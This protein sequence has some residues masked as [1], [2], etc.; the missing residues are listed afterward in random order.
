MGHSSS[1][2]C[3][4]CTFSQTFL[5][6]VGFDQFEYPFIL[7][8]LHPFAAEE[9]M[10]IAEQTEHFQGLAHYQ[11]VLQ[12]TDCQLLFSEFDVVVVLQDDEQISLKHWCHECNGSAIGVDQDRIGDYPCPNCKKTSLEMAEDEIRIMW[13]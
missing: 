9:L 2:R 10:S 3:R 6:G 8:S 11:H 1:I 4:D 5:V 7:E 13:D 12:C